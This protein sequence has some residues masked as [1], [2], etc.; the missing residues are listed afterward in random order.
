MVLGFHEEGN[1]VI[2]DGILQFLQFLDLQVVLLGDGLSLVVH[3]LAQGLNLHPGGILQLLNVSIGQELALTAPR[4][5]QILQFGHPLVGLSLK[6]LWCLTS[7][8][9]ALGNDNCFRQGQVLRSRLALA[10]GYGPLQGSNLLLESLQIAGQLFVQASQLLVSLGLHLADGLFAG[11][12]SERYLLGVLRLA[13]GC[14][15]LHLLVQGLDGLVAGGLVHGSDDELGEV[16][17]PLQ[18]AR[19][20]VQKEAD[21]A[22]QALDEPD[23]GHRRGQLDVAHAL[24]AHLAAGYLNAALV[25]DDTLVAN[26][27]VL[28]AVAL[29]ILGGPEYLLAEQTVLLRLQG[30]V[31]DGFR[32]GYLPIGPGTDLLRRSQ[33]YAD[34]VKVIH[35]K[36]QVDPPPQSLTS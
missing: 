35:F 28:A 22:G 7:D 36:S 12:L 8:L 11:G 4:S 6:P 25:T 19:R 23:V 9:P 30:A 24:A 17:Y 10:L 31:V 2:A 15:C 16:E 32:L 14:L 34:G 13:F 1:G 33:R 3:L 18:A 21:A 29:E 20:H 27:L 26:S 5:E